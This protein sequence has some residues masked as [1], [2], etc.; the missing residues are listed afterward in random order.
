[1]AETT[2]RDFLIA[3]AALAPI[4]AAQRSSAGAGKP[5]ALPNLLFMIADDLTYRAIHSLNNGEVQT[6]NLDRLVKRGC[7]ELED[8]LGPVAVRG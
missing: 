4:A 2:R 7:R 5:A 1:V 8:D 3:G 6:P